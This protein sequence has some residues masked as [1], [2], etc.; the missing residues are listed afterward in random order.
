MKGKLTKKKQREKL[1]LAN[2]VERIVRE[3]QSQMQEDAKETDLNTQAIN[4]LKEEGI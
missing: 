2:D 3:G 4:E 1:E